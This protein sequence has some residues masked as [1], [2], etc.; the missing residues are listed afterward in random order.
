[1]NVNQH[2]VKEIENYRYEKYSFDVHGLNKFITKSADFDEKQRLAIN[3]IEGIM[4]NHGKQ[5]LR[6]HLVELARIEYGIQELQS[7]ARDHVVHALL[8]YVLGAFINENYLNSKNGIHVNEFQWKIS[9]LFHDVGYPAQV[10]KEAILG[11]LSETINDIAAGIGVSTEK[12]VFKVVPVNLEKLTNN[13]NSF[14][15]IQREI[16][17]WEINI[18]ARKEYSNLT[19]SGGICH[20]MISALS[21]LRVIDLMYQRHNP[22]R[23]FKDIVL[24]N[25]DW[26]QRWFEEDV[27]P[28]CAAIF[29]HNL[30]SHCFKSCKIDK[31]KAPLAFLLK[32][33]DCLQEW[34][35]PSKDLP[36]GY[37][38]EKFGITITNDELILSADISETGKSQIRKDLS[39]A[40][41]ASDI[42]IV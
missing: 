10:A 17:S 39:G 29:L 5:R 7:W 4:I 22:K 40:L 34:E 13:L 18:D 23:E 28:A 32:L 21:V 42:K 14:D 35:R 33:S 1:M 26:N 36:K 6:R 25:V 19:E 27:I 24:D 30:P 41:L 37:P 8:C 2:L 11:P 12:V 15:L 38:S 31:H 3:L 9:C 16:D 20:G